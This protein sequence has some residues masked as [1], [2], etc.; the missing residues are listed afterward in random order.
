VN[1]TRSLPWVRS[2]VGET[3]RL[4]EVI[5]VNKCPAPRPQSPARASALTS[6]PFAGMLLFPRP[7]SG[8]LCI[9]RVSR[10]KR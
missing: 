4:R 9:V 8:E 5:S 3:Y 2:P 10:T 7:F 1:S 6:P